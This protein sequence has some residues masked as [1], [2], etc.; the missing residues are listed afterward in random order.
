MA[1]KH[2]LVVDDEPGITLLCERLLKKEGFSVLSFIKAREAMAYIEKNHVDLLLVDIRMPD[3]SGFDVIARAR[4]DQPDLAVLVMTGYGTVEM[5]IQALR[6]GVDGLILKPFASAEELTNA[7]RQ[8]LADNQQKRDI[9]RVQ[10]LRPLFD[11]TESLISET[12]PEPLLD[13]ILN[14]ICGHMRCDNAAVYHLSPAEDRLKLL[15]GRGIQPAEEKRSAEGGIIGRTSA[16]G[17]PVWI[18]AVGPGDHVLQK[19]LI[20]L[21]LSSAICVPIS[22]LNIHAVLFAGRGAD[23]PHFREGDWEMFL[24]LARQAIL[25]M[26]NAR[27]YDELRDYIKRVEGSQKALVQAEKMAAAGRLTASIAHEINNPL[28]A[29][30]NCIHLASR[31]EFPEE[32]RKNYIE[33][34]ESEL[35]RLMLTVQRMLEFYRP[36]AVDPQRVDV[37]E[38]MNRVVSLLTPQ[39]DH[40][41]IRITTNYTDRLPKVLA[42]SSQLQQVFINIM[43]NAYDAMPTGGELTINVRAV[44]DAVEIIFQDTGPGVPPERQNLIFEPFVSTKEGGTGLG[45]AVSYGIISAHGG[46]LELLA[47]HGPGA[48]FRISIPVKGKKT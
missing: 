43:L 12:R 10:A 41:K 31:N 47:D 45:L 39:M 14:A 17:L 2:I 35:E 26:E 34:A 28:Q 18:N 48:C 16:L 30:R 40:R 6:Q 11:L 29:V 15:A 44:K 7:V 8:A 9:A 27:L 13:M 46:S 21:Q 5:A 36:G 37:P 3:V 23:Q 20:K 42:V 32:K 4:S 22:R 25:A 33:L 24:L 19:K 1:E 38:L